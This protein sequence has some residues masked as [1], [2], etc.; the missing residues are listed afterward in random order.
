VCPQGQAHTQTQAQENL[1]RLQ[2]RLR[3][4]Q[5]QLALQS[6]SP[7]SASKIKKASPKLI[8]FSYTKSAKTISY[9]EGVTFADSENDWS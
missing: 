7:L 2:Q 4:L 3:Q 1:E 5:E 6:T 8:N 9:L